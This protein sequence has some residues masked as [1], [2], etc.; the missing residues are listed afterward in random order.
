[1]TRDE[2]MEAPAT[3]Y[4]DESSDPANPGWVCEL[5]NGEQYQ[6]DATSPATT[7][8]DLRGEAR[9]FTTGPI[10]IRLSVTEEQDD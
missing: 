7:S 4:Y 1:M 3:V 10:T 8:Q 9:A 5:A 6:L 2:A